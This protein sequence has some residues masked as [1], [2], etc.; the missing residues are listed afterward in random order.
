MINKFQKA[1]NTLKGTRVIFAP[2]ADDIMAS[3]LPQKPFK[4]NFDPDSNITHVSN[5]FRI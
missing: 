3:F 4:D 1:C 5:P 2:G